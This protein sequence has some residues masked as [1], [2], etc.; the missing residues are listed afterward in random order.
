MFFEHFIDFELKFVSN[1][2][3][4]KEQKFYREKVSSIFKHFKVYSG[5][6]NL[7]PNLTNGLLSTRVSLDSL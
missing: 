7:H 3:K 4:K 1:K 6:Q 5:G 2:M